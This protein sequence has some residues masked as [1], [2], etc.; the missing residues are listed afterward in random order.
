[1][2][3]LVRRI[4]PECRVPYDP[5]PEEQAIWEKSGM[6]PKTAFFHGEGCVFCAQTGYQGRIGVYEVMKVT[7]EMRALV[8]ANANHD[9]LKELA[10]EQGMVT[11]QEQALRLVE[12]DVTTV[13]EIMRTIYVI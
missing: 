13:A 3:R 4:C 2:Q 8:V 7:D 6:A 12:K 1:V 9:D 11:L 10:V 5:T